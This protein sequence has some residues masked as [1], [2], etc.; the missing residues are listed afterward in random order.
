MGVCRRKV[1]AVDGDG[2][3]LDVDALLMRGLGCWGFFFFRGR[4]TRQ[5]IG[6]GRG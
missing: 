3:G 6:G 1:L 4:P 2:G 5:L